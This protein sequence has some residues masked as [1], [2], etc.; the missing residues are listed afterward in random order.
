MPTSPTIL[1]RSRSVLP[2]CLKW[3]QEDNACFYDPIEI[4]TKMVFIKKELW[5]DMGSPNTITVTIEPG[6]C[7]NLP[8]PPGL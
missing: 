5:A 8:I 6:D 4:S 7:L 3:S 2:I 1:T